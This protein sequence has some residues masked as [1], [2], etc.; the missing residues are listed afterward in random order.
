MQSIENINTPF[1]INKNNS[2]EKMFNI[3]IE[4]IIKLKTLL[5]MCSLRIFFNLKIAKDIHIIATEYE[6][7]YML[8]LVNLNNL[9]KINANAV[10]KRPQLKKCKAICFVPDVNT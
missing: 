2:I 1:S 8:S 4:L 10:I 3:I 7:K 6:I 9:T 5:L